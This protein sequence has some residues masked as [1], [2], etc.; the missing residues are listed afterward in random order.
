MSNVVSSNPLIIDTAG[1]DVL[2]SGPLRIMAFNWVPSDDIAT[3]D[4]VTVTDKHAVVKYA[5]NV[6]D[7]GT[8]ANTLRG[9]SFVLP[10][11]LVIDGLVVSVLDDG[12]LYIYLEQ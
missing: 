5:D 4:G 8:A 12:T 1:A 11:P 10:K 7:T 3:G 9:R 2:V 6:G